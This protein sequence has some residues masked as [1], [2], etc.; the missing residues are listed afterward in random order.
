MYVTACVSQVLIQSNQLITLNQLMSSEIKSALSARWFSRGKRFLPSFYV[1]RLYSMD[2]S[3]LRLIWQTQ[4][5]FNSQHFQK[6][7]YQFPHLSCHQVFFLPAL[8]FS[9]IDTNTVLSS[10]SACQP[11]HTLI[12]TY[13]CVCVC[14]FRS[15]ESSSF[16]VYVF[17][18]LMWS[19]FPTA[20]SGTEILAVE[21][22]K[23]RQM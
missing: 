11:F 20:F 22:I 15:A 17:V 19:A 14:V 21:I 8:I 6:L 4:P 2:I 7:S 3:H 18:F 10:S 9:H 12:C 16:V 23:W 1:F 13:T 5:P